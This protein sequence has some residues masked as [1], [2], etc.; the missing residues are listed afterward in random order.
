M[1][2]ILLAFAALL[3]LA[4][5]FAQ[6]RNAAPISVQRFLDERSLIDRLSRENKTEALSGIRP[7]YVSPRVINGIKM[8]DAFIDF[9][10]TAVLQELKAHG[11]A[12]NCEFDGFVTAQVPVDR[13]VEISRLPGVTNVEI[14][15]QLEL[16]TD[17]TL[18]VTNAGQVLN[19]TEFGLPQAFDG[20]G[21]VIGIIDNGFDYQHGA[22]K[23]TDSVPRSRIVRVYDVTNDSGHPASLDGNVLPGSIFMDEQID[24]LT[25]DGTGTHGTHVAAIAAGTHIDGYG[26]MAPGADLVLC[27]SPTL[28]QGVS[29]VEVINC[30]KYMYAYADSVGKPCVI[31]ISVSTPDGPHDGKDRISKAAE[32]TTGPGHIFVIA[33]G[34]TAGKYL[35]AHGPVTMERTHNILLGYYESNWL[36]DVSCYYPNVWIDS[37]IRSPGVRPVVAFHIYDKKDKRIVWE[38]EKIGLYKIFDPAEFAPYFEI[39]TSKDSTAFVKALVSQYSSG[40]YQL[41]TTIYNLKSTSIEWDPNKGLYASRYQIGMSFYA[42][43]TLYPRQPDS[44]YVDTWICTNKAGYYNYDYG[45]YV[46]S[47]S[48]QGDTITNWIPNYYTPATDYCSIGSYAISDSVISAGGF[49]ARNSFYSLYLGTTLTSEATIGG[50]YTVSSYEVEGSGP[51]GKA[52]PTVVAPAYDVVSAVSRY[53]Y[54]SDPNKTKNLVRKDDDGSLWGV[55]SGTSMATPTVAGIIAQWLQLKPDLT[56]SD[57]KDII[58]H[59]AVKDEFYSQRFGPN[60]KIDAMAGVQYLL[61]LMPVEIIP[62]DVNGTG[63]VDIQDL[64]DV[65]DVILGHPSPDII[66]E[67]VDFNGDGL[68][69]INDVT[70]M[71]YY[72]LTGET[73]SE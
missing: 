27:L 4:A 23:T 72:I 15:R 19:G 61:S 33:A 16:C 30:I 10:S 36:S 52:L 42:P 21:V 63:I 56:P 31:S 32:Q 38:S 50:V 67:A 66:M 57:V 37:W 44:C 53:S 13:L 35:Y 9:E 41:S 65:I 54:F 48:E 6:L 3:S 12:V 26:G 70:D 29:E 14:S 11:V 68:V 58:A 25:T 49:V 69:D 71:V 73:E 59:T 47:I 5:G 24:S 17:S 40:K 2:R 51:T 18:S 55:M 28:N 39:D 43:R 46:D 34:N 8:V 7:V 62:G 22:F 64:A 45:I 60:G 1:K 20:T